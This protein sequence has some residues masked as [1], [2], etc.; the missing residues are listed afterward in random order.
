GDEA[1]T[2][3]IPL[4]RLGLGNDARFVIRNLFTDEILQWTGARQS[5]WIG[6]G[7]PIFTFKLAELGDA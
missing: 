6:P 3:E 4:K 2:I 7:Q 1:A 5:I